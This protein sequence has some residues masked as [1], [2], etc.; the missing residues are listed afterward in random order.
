MQRIFSPA[1]AL[2]NRMSY[3][4]K[5][6]LLWLVSLVPIA[7]VVYSL[8]AS[9]ERVIQPSQ[10]ELQGLALI[11]PISRTVQLMQQ[12]RGFSAVLFGGNE[13]MRDRRAAKETEATKAFGAM[14]KELPPG[15]TA[16]EEFRSIKA[17]W[18]RLR[19]EGHRWTAEENF[20][21]HTRLIERMQSFELSI[22]DDYALILDPETATFY[23]IDTAI[24]KLPHAFEHLGQL[25]AYGTGILAKK[26][27]TESQ[28][29]KLNGLVAELDGTLKELRV[30]IEKTARHNPAVR[31]TLP[32]AADGIVG[33]ARKVTDVVASDILAGRF[34]T[35][36]DVFLDM[37]TAEIDKS[38]AQ[39]HEIMLPTAKTLIAARIARAENTLL[40]SVGVALLLF[41]L[42][43]YILISI[44]YAI[45]GS[46]RSLVHSAHTFAEGDL[47]QRIKL[48]TRDELSQIGDSFNKMA[49]GFNALLEERKRTE[50]ALQQNQELLNEAQRLGKLGCWVLDMVSGELRWSDEVYRIFELDPAQF[51]PSYEN[52]LNVIDPDDRDKV[53]RAY[54][55]SLEDR[56]PYDIEHRLRF[57]DGRI[58]WVH[59]HCSSEFDV[60]GKPL[61]SV[62]A[63]QDV[64]ER[65]QAEL[66]LREYQQLLREL[67]AQNVASRE[68][69]AKHIAREVHDE[70]GQLLTALRMDVSLLRIQFGTRDPDLMKKSKEMLALVDKA[71]QGVRD[72]TANLRPAALDMGIVPAIEWLCNNISGRTDTACTLRVINDPVELDEDRIVVIFRIVQESLTNVMR[73]A[74]AN[75]VEITIGLRGSDV[76]VEVCDDGKGFNPAAL[77]PKESFGLMGMRE[78]AL[79]VGGKVEI[80]SAPSKGTGVSV[81]IPVKPRGSVS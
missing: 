32:K 15:L 69:E 38:Y 19:E 30:N 4:K 28:K 71:I 13:A 31:G 3:T 67:A 1:I 14:E 41:L 20:A 23:L 10:L 16:S 56:R 21:A 62:G 18:V 68:S 55:Q 40:V 36:P 34:A 24:N 33:S 12:H 80:T 45:I 29:A 26:Q 73:Y 6:T 49:E 76:F 65:K 25:R 17:S 7:V 5:F 77:S 72:V 35:P 27:I 74:E 44:Y 70:L 47:N 48:G 51:S 64:T 9:L 42:V 59:E 43:V 60:S 63:V 66:D 46:I 58:K 81:S 22:A 39:L 54:T 11:E 50:L 57:A 53:N 8:F 52:F 75:S 61:R 2:L 79:A 37:A 78:R